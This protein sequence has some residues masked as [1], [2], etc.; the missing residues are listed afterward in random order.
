[1]SYMVLITRKFGIWMILIGI[2]FQFLNIIT[3][4]YWGIGIDIFGALIFIMG[5]IITI[6]KWKR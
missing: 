6:V 1:M 2:A 5:I 4:G 3:Y